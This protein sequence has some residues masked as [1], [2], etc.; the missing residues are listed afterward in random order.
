MKV[1]NIEVRR[2][3][4]AA[5]TFSENFERIENADYEGQKLL[6]DREILN[7]CEIKPDTELSLDEIKELV[8]VSECFR[9]KEKAVWYLSK[10]DLSEKGLYDKLRK[11]FSEKASAFALQQMVKRGYIDDRRYAENLLRILTERKVSSRAAVGKM[12][13]KG[14]PM[15]IIKEVS[16]GTRN[17]DAERAEALLLTKYKNKMSN[18]DDLRRTVAALMRR[19]FVYSDIKTALNMFASGNEEKNG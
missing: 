18:E 4:L 10:G 14:V 6:V 3:H 2:R 1:L 12:L 9:A 5:V 16:E 11:N 13:E 15:T 19:G 17:T 8:L 7:R